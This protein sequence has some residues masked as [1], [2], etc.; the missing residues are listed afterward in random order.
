[1][2]HLVLLVVYGPPLTRLRWGKEKTPEVR[3]KGRVSYRT[4]SISATL[5]LRWRRAS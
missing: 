1:M 2:P 3:G 5:A 4:G